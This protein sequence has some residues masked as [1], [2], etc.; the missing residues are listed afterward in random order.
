MLNVLPRHRSRA[1]C[2]C[3][4]F[5]HRVAMAVFCVSHGNGRECMSC[6]PAD[7]WTA[8]WIKCQHHIAFAHW[9]LNCAWRRP[10][11]V[12]LQLQCT[13]HSLPRII[14]FQRSSQCT[15][16]RIERFAFQQAFAPLVLIVLSVGQARWQMSSATLFRACFLNNF[17][18]L[19]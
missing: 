6:E 15:S 3:T 11:L 17:A 9:S 16:S 4:C 13:L 18:T 19:L 10:C 12:E 1:F 8:I 7:G 2:R 14:L 5:P